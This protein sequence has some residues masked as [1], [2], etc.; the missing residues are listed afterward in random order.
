M[1]T[2]EQHLKDALPVDRIWGEVDDPVLR[3]VTCGGDFDRS[4]RSYRSNVIVYA[5]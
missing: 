4:R 1:H 2:R 5:S 3:L